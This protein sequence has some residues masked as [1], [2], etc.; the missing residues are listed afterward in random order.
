MLKRTRMLIE[1]EQRFSCC[2]FVLR[3]VIGSFSLS[4]Q[5]PSYSCSPSICLPCLAVQNISAL[6][7]HMLCFWSFPPLVACRFGV[8]SE[9]KSLAKCCHTI[10]QGQKQEEGWNYTLIQTFWRYLTP[11]VLSLNSLSTVHDLTRQKCQ[12]KVHHSTDRNRESNEKQ[13]GE[14]ED[15]EPRERFNLWG[16]IRLHCFSNTTQWVEK[17]ALSSLPNTFSKQFLSASE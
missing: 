11:L 12:Q 7:W 2:H 17:A 5:R 6:E 8:F 9:M 1:A 16:S 10:V 3:L 13:P 4:A 15:D 14:G